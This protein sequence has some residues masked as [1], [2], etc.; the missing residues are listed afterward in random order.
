MLI[1][2]LRQGR[3][4]LR[5]R[6]SGGFNERFINLAATAGIDL[7]DVK[8]AN[9][10]LFACTNVKS[11]RKLRKVARQSGMR[12]CV[13]QRHGA[14]FLLQRFRA[15]LGVAVGLAVFFAVV[16]TLSLF[17]WSVHISGSETLT[18]DQVREALSSLGLDSG[19]LKSSLNLPVLKREA[20]LNLPELSW[21]TLR[22]KG[23]TVYVELRE[24]K[25][26]PDIIPQ[27]TPCNIV[28]ARG[29]Q[30]LRTQT[31]AG[32]SLVK[33][34]D[35]VAEG[36]PLI[37]G[38]SEN[39]FGETLLHH[40][41]GEIIAAT[42][43]VLTQEVPLHQ[44][45]LLPTG[46]VIRRQRFQL[47]GVEIPLSLSPAPQGENYQRQVTKTPV[48]LFGAQLPAALFVEEW[49]ELKEEEVTYSQGEAAQIAEEALEKTIAEELQDVLITSREKRLVVEN[50][51]LSYQ[52]TLYCEENIAREAEILIN[53]P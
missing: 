46:H 20:M 22:L 17:V 23:G 8:A 51:T 52:L 16:Y 14:P 11:Y 19:V 36:D 2:L 38:V 45:L 39:V 1:W 26:A 35:V 7:W 47:F 10:V 37:S 9:G 31:I 18:E 30:I 44:K 21:I 53:Q 13:A 33:P 49:Q 12:L 50:G 48:T 24:S 29:G 4:Y 28:A 43:R 42:V 6:A 32:Q 25:K 5:I 41:G 15:R 3:G 40:A 34:G 27:D